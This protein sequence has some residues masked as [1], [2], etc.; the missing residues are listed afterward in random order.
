ML[1][2]IITSLAIII[3]CSSLHSQNYVFL[4]DSITAGYDLDK[5]Y[6]DYP[7]VNSGVGGYTTKD[8]LIINT[9]DCMPTIM[10][11]ADL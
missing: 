9:F 2:I 3:T 8:M 5:F 10:S 4:G 1:R 6:K 7:V 11:G